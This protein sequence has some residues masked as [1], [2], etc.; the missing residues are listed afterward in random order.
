MNYY[1]S[2]EHSKPIATFQLKCLSV[3][4]V[5]VVTQQPKC[6]IIMYPTSDNV[7]S[8]KLPHTSY[9]ILQCSAPSHQCQTL[10]RNEIGISGFA[11]GHTKSVGLRHEL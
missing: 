7:A 3:A 5:S 11:Q 8:I 1:R 2:P 9:I 10:H 6:T 4:K